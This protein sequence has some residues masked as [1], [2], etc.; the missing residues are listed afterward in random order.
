MKKLITLFII[1]LLV[2]NLAAQTTDT[3]FIDIDGVKIHTVLTNPTNSTSVP[4]AIIIAGSGP[5]DLNGNQPMFQN[6]SLRYLSDALVDKDF[7][8]LRFDK[9]AIAKSVIPNFN[10]ADLSIDIYAN[11]LLKLIDFTKT[12]G[13]S[14][15]FLIG[16]SEGSLI[17]LIA[18]QKADVSGFISIAG[19][20]NPADEGLK[21]QLKP[22]L[23]PTM[24]DQAVSIID[25][26]KNGYTV[27]N[28]P[29]HFYALFRPSVQP[30]L[31]S[32]FKYDPAILI[33]HVKCP[34]LIT[35][36]DNDLQVKI[37]DAQKLVEALP[38]SQLL[39]I[40]GMNHVLKTI[41]GDMQENISAY[42]NPALPVNQE[43]TSGLINFMKKN[44]KQ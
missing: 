15:I 3:I 24:F 40:P 6:N 34:S 25:S 11:D 20:G 27:K 43:L 22:K 13:F 1:S 44:S 21:S 4:L 42:T 23:P 30:Y 2:I 31:I 41:E 36:G 14:E 26:L 7:A 38:S 32:W 19:A 39:I 28:I 8:T 16:H 33:S 12:K 37:E 29:S 18:L 9:R 5:T 35:Q 17:A 10:E